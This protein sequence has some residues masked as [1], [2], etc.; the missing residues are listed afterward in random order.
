MHDRSET[1]CDDE[2]KIVAGDPEVRKFL[3]VVIS[4]VTGNAVIR[5]FRHFWQ[6]LVWACA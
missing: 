4:E 6:L 5:R 1:S 3:V 2:N